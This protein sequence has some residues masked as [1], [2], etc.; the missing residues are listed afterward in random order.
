MN[1]DIYKRALNSERDNPK[2]SLQLYSGL[3]KENQ[4]FRLDILFICLAGP[5]GAYYLALWIRS[6][7]NVQNDVLTLL[8]WF[9]LGLY[10]GYLIYEWRRRKAR[11]IHHSVVFDVFFLLVNSLSLFFSTASYLIAICAVAAICFFLLCLMIGPIYFLFSG[12]SFSFWSIFSLPPYLNILI[13]GISLLYGF[14]LVISDPV[15]PDEDLGSY[16]LKFKR[17][18]IALQLRS[19]GSVFILISVATLI[20]SDILNLNVIFGKP[21]IG[22]TL[23]LLG[24]LFFSLEYGYIERDVVLGHLLRLAMVRCALQKGQIDEADLRLMLAEKQSLDIKVIFVKTHSAYPKTIIPLIEALKE[25]VM[26][27]KYNVKPDLT[28]IADLHQ[29]AKAGIEE[30]DPNYEYCLDAIEKTEEILFVYKKYLAIARVL[31]SQFFYPPG[32]DPSEYERWEY[33]YYKSGQK[34]DIEV[35]DGEI[36]LNKRYKKG[37][38]ITGI[39]G[40]RKTEQGFIQIFDKLKVGDMVGYYT[41]RMSFGTNI[42]AFER[43]KYH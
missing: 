28:N 19:K 6:Y 36:Y 12:I 18:I 42:I 33:E 11:L 23:S 34:I 26:C 24:G 43:I 32:E 15:R 22:L 38:R 21:I 25:T 31:K 3:Q 8:L 16:L 9:G 29:D 37:D 10:P 40:C 30:N 27:K 14:V 2:K 4:I 20:A 1:R 41:Y 13:V 39:W 35:I 7:Y 5:I 17:M